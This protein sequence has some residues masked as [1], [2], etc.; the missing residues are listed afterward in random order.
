MLQVEDRSNKNWNKA[1]S[2]DI[3]RYLPSYIIP[4][5]VGFLTITLWTRQVAPDEFARYSL[6][7]SAIWVF[8]PLFSW[9]P[10][11]IL[12]YLAEA[13]S[14]GQ[15]RSFFSAS[16]MVFFILFAAI[17][18]FGYAVSASIRRVGD[19]SDLGVLIWYGALNLLG[20]A[21]F[22]FIS[23]FAQARR[24]SIRYGVYSS[25]YRI[26]LLVFS[27]MLMQYLGPT[28]RA[29]LLAGVIADGS[30]FAYDFVRNWRGRQLVA[31][32][33]WTKQT[34][35]RM[36]SFG[37][38]LA[39]SQEARWVLALSDRYLLERLS[40]LTQVG[41]YVAAYE[42]ADK[43]I[44]VF[45]VAMLTATFP[46]IV[47]AETKDGRP[48]ATDLLQRSLKMYITAVFGVLILLAALT[49]DIVNLV[50]GPQYRT[51]ITYVVL[52]TVSSGVAMLGAAD[53]LG[54][55]L[56]LRN[57]TKQI[58]LFIFFAGVVNV[59]LNLLLI[60][61]IGAIGAALNTLLSYGLLFG[62][63]LAFE[64]RKGAMNLHDLARHGSRVFGVA[65]IIVGLSYVVFPI[66][67]HDWESLAVKTI[68]LEF[69]YIL[70][71]LFLRD[72]F[73][74]STFHWLLRLK[75]RQI[76]SKF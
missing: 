18:L 7:M 30:L 4:A 3:L 12:R 14:E 37:V 70:M 10:H 38:P 66:L 69:T 1:L 34:V 47:A 15:E 65:V 17:G 26:G 28:A 72:E 76:S 23:A 54:Q 32:T 8:M 20:R 48:A 21:G 6:V 35:L 11:A 43:V 5:G 51:L 24:E 56:R 45:S 49:V 64:T 75:K 44:A 22:K 40:T 59:F 60:P 19:A 27:L 33:P 50:L 31:I 57:K 62:I 61:L 63:M 39:L 53:F 52:P 13:Q 73:A 29:L 9:L 46:V 58:A 71:L 67:G 55:M 68:L 42:V 41:L 36:V 2:V 16:I 25:L 74:V